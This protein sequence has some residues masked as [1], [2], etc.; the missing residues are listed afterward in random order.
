MPE[1]KVKSLTRE[2]LF[3]EDNINKCLDEIKNLVMLLKNEERLYDKQKH[4]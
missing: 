4:P 3:V 1:E 2:K